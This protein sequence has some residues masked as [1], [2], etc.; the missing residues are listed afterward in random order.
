MVATPLSPPLVATWQGRAMA[1]AS[2][3]LLRPTR[4]KFDSSRPSWV[5]PGLP[6]PHRPSACRRR[7][8]P[9]S[10]TTPNTHALL[11]ALAPLRE[12]AVAVAVPFAPFAVRPPPLGLPT[13]PSPQERDAVSTPSC[14]YAKL[15][16]SPSAC[17]NLPEKSAHT[18]KR[19][20]RWIFFLELLVLLT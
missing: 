15:F 16:F 14:S 6:A 10:L 11:C 9:S 2:L 18:N 8:R 1:G 4:W 20:D 7:H 12:D 5:I 13:S 17:A 19:S 3:S